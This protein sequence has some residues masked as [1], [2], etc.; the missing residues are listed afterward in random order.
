M[1]IGIVGSRSIKNKKAVKRAVAKSPWLDARG[2]IP[3]SEW[4]VTIISGGANGVDSSAKEIAEDDGFDMKIIE[5]DWDDWSNGHP[6]LERNT[7][8]VNE[9]DRVIAVWDGHSDG[10]RDTIDKALDRAVPIYV[11]IVE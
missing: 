11:H 1:N 10:T 7:E 5:P 2:L 6:A 3:P 9:S 8:I 4:S